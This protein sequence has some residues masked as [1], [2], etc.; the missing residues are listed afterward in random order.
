M[1]PMVVRGTAALAH[2]HDPTVYPVEADMGEHLLQ[3]NIA[4]FLRGLLSRL[5]ATR[6]EVALVG[7]DQ[8]IYWQK[9]DPKKVVAPDVYVLPGVD[10]DTLVPCWKT[11]ERGLAPSFALEVVSSNDVDKDYRRSP[12]RYAALGVDEL[13]L[14]DPEHLM[15]PDRV[16]WQVY[17]RL[18]RRGFVRVA[19]TDDDR[20]E[21]RALGCWLRV[22]GSEGRLRVRVG[23]GADG[24]ELF[25]SEAEA[26]RAEAS[27]ERRKATAAL[28][29]AATERARAAAEIAALQAELARLRGT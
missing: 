21:S 16:R 12:E 5:L 20:V 14:F 26:L 27:A 1:K 28:K 9:G 25:A 24:S 13:V 19:A 8:F 29:K 10:P 17:R 22:V 6:G 4:E 18:K 11:W 23:L 3:R 7:A 2:D 15:T